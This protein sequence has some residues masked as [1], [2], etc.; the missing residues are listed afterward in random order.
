[1]Q[2]FH[3]EEFILL[4]F[5]VTNLMENIVILLKIDNIRCL[6]GNNIN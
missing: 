4:E 2:K 3:F 5:Q 1:M 6:N